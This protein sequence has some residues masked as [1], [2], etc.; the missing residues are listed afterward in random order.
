MEVKDLAERLRKLLPSEPSQIGADLRNNSRAL[1]EAAL[2]RLNLVTRE[3]F[4][5]QTALLARTREKLDR[6][7]M[8]IAELEKRN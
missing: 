2:A 4:E 6:L 7:E 3:E 5:A 8:L 1:F